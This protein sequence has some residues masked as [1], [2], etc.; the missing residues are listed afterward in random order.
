MIS[1]DR[2]TYDLNEL[3]DDF[4]RRHDIVKTQMVQ[5]ESLSIYWTVRTK[6]EVDAELGIRGDELTKTESLW[7]LLLSMLDRTFEY[8]EG[9]IVAYVTGSTGASEV[10]SR[11]V[12]ESAVNLAYILVDEE[13]GNRLT[14]YFSQYFETELEEIERWLK[15]SED[16]T[17]EAKSVHRSSALNKRVA[18]NWLREHIDAALSQIGLPTTE[19]TSSKWP[20]VAKR[21]EALG[22]EVAY[23]TTYAALCS[24]T[25]S[26]AE[27]LLNYF[28]FKSIGNQ[29]LLNKAA[30]ETVNFSRLMLYF[31]VQ[32][33]LIAAG[34]YSM[35]FGLADS[36][37]SIVSGREAIHKIQEEIALQLR[38]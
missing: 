24:Q 34:C 25:H 30:L 28:V 27:D 14:R 23:R 17:G 10:I 32:Y 29:D 26:D 35:R 18:I 36:L 31:A 7:A 8:L 9:S 13:G 11:T 33:Y 16:M 38:E 3:I 5:R 20:T 12:V 4:V 1:K 21:F 22:L 19:Q 2:H 37:A 15:L 6:L